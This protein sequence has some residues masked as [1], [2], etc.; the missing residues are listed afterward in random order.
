MWT[1]PSFC[2]I[3]D[4]YGDNEKVAQHVLAGFVNV[5][6]ELW[7]CFSPIMGRIFDE[8]Y[9]STVTDVNALL[10]DAEDAFTSPA[11]STS[12]KFFL[13]CAKIRAENGRASFLRCMIE[14]RGVPVRK[15][16]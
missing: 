8:G 2:S 6:R 13:P 9:Y 4:H 11:L 1:S 3:G 5:A 7:V 15:H 16:C 14:V 12:S 10:R